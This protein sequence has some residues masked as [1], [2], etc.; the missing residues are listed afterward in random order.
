MTLDTPGSLAITPM[1]YD[2]RALQYLYGSRIRNANAT[3][4]TF[5]TVY[6][7][8]VAN[9][10]FGSTNTQLKQ[11]LW[12]AGGV[13]TLDF[14]GLAAGASYRFD[15]NPGGLLTTQSSY[16]GSTYYDYGQDSKP[17]DGITQ[18]PQYATSS[19]WHHDRLWHRN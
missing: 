14:S 2:I 9:Q 19:F 10:F 16:N 17:R 8:S 18:G 3:T 5:N 6:G 7:Y 12:D 13:D 15:L 4:Y 1:D 11:S